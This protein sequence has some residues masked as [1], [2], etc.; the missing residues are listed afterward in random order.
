MLVYRVLLPFLLL[1]YVHF[2]MLLLELAKDFLLLKSITIGQSHGL[3][4]LIKLYKKIHY[5]SSYWNM[6][7]FLDLPSSS[8]PWLVFHHPIHPILSFQAGS[9]WCQSWVHL[10]RHS[11]TKSF[12]CSF[13]NAQIL[14]LDCLIHRKNHGQSAL[15]SRLFYAYQW[16]KCYHPPWFL[17]IIRPI[18]IEWDRLGKRIE[19]DTSYLPR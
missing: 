13:P 14:L 7:L 12:D 3:L 15:H 2:R 11:P 10:S 5:N 16:S 18:Q 4:T 19:R 6:I 9:S 8:P 17:C 1:T